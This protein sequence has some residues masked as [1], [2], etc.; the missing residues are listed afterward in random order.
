ML[1][2]KG[3]EV[4]DPTPVSVPVGYGRPES[5]QDQIRRMVHLAS[6]EAAAAGAESFEEADDFD[7]GDD[8]DPSS[9]WELSADQ[10]GFR[11]DRIPGWVAEAKKAGWAPPV[12]WE[13]EASKAGWTKAPSAGAKGSPEP[14]EA[15]A[16]S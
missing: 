15:P 14:P 7:V 5:L 9:P 16:K 1:D 6:A 3:H 8:F 10:E 11:P 4:P 12:P 13:Q 2:Q